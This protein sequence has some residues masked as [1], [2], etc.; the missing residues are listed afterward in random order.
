M[1]F[2]ILSTEDER[3]RELFERPEKATWLMLTPAHR[4]AG[5]GKQ[6]QLRLHCIL[7][8]TG[9][10]DR[11]VVPP[12]SNNSS[13]ACLCRAPAGCPGQTWLS[14]QHRLESDGRPW[15]ALGQ[16]LGHLGGVGWRHL[17]QKLPL[18]EFPLLTLGR[19]R[20]IPLLPLRQISLEALSSW[21]EGKGPLSLWLFLP[22]L[23]LT[24]H[25]SVLGLWGRAVTLGSFPQV[26][27]CLGEPGTGQGCCRPPVCSDASVWGQR[28]SKTNPTAE[29]S[30]TGKHR[31]QR[32]HRNVE[33]SPLQLQ[34]CGCL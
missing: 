10:N 12:K 15:A 23:S 4:A 20:W 6:P 25:S 3:R 29:N 28:G 7:R 9:Q 14:S 16:A 8:D 13:S 31:N 18:S 11:I 34:A 22:P 26:L 17:A 30:T 2:N 24:P 33:K 19:G 5:H 1:L 21:R 32:S 27:P